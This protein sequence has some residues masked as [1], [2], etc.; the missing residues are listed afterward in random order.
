MHVLVGEAAEETDQLRIGLPVELTWTER[1]GA[2]FPAF[3]PRGE[4]A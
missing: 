3:R 4:V 2:P 1:E